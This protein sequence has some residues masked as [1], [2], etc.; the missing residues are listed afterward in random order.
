MTKSNK[1]I[2]FGDLLSYGAEGCTYKP[3]L[4][5]K[6]KTHLKNIDPITGIPE[7]YKDKISKYMTTKS[8]LK[9]KKEY[10]KIKK[11]PDF[12]DFYLGSPKMCNVGP[13]LTT[14]KSLK[15]KTSPFININ[16][17][18]TN[19]I[20]VKNLENPFYFDED[21]DIF[22]NINEMYE[23]FKCD[24]KNLVKNKMFKNKDN[25]N[26]GLQD[27]KLLIMKYGGNVLAYFDKIFEY[28]NIDT[29][30]NS[31]YNKRK[32]LNKITKKDMQLFLFEYFRMLFGIKQMVKHNFIHRDIKLYNLVYNSKINRLNFIDFGISLNFSKYDDTKMS[33]LSFNFPPEEIFFQKSNNRNIFNYH[34]LN[35]LI[36]QYPS[37]DDHKNY[38]IKT[39]FNFNT[40]VDYIQKIE[41][42]EY[43][44]PTTN[45]QFKILLEKIDQFYYPHLIQLFKH[46]LNY[47]DSQT[48]LD[49]IKTQMIKKTR[50]TYDLYSYSIVLI[51]IL[52]M[53]KYMKKLLTKDE[54]NDLYDI[55]YKGI[56]PNVFIRNSIDDTIE[57]FIVFFNKFD[58]INSIKKTEYYKNNLKY[59][60][61][62]DRSSSSFDINLFSLNKTANTYSPELIPPDIS[63]RITVNVLSKEKHDYE[64]SNEY[65]KTK[66]K[67]AIKSASSFIN[68]L[69]SIAKKKIHSRIPT[70]MFH[71]TQKHKHK[72][73]II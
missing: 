14:Y 29:K 9:E 57:D 67:V 41:R 39:L 5:C 36:K 70:P 18:Q 56:N 54:R 4:Y 50:S 69:D 13:Y 34:T 44:K 32:R 55:A 15:I 65:I 22:Y 47:K 3:S 31:T 11:I 8:A 7:Y 17:K 6:N 27:K 2:A 63:R 52:N 26:K 48:Q 72:P 16:G 68:S 42:I 33:G 25:F 66:K 59:F 10:D 60:K 20:K 12:D 37:F 53:S 21:Y 23:D 71:K 64:K 61:N 35:N 28:G 1:K 40:Y 24:N 38:Y 43:Y 49:N 58:W 30:N 62:V 46:I 19:K 51:E 73:M 45:Q